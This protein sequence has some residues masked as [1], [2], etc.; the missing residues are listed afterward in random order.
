MQTIVF[1]VT[2]LIQLYIFVLLLRV[3]MQ[4]VRADFYNPFSQFV[5][6]AT[7]PIVGP[8]RRLIPSVGSID[9]ATLL[10]AFVLAIADIIF[11]MWA[12]NMLPAIGLT[13]LPMGLILLLTYIGKLIFW[14]ILIRAILSW[15]S[16]GRNPVDYL[17]FQL[18]EPLMAP[19]RRIIPAMGGLDFSA[20]I[21][22]FILIALNY[23][24]VD[25][26]LMIDPALTAMLFSVGIM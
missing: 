9:T 23:L 6:K 3:W 7:Q 1:V 26:S 20:M 22:M 25:V 24:R 16:Q 19:I 13:I 15:V 10:V 2:T 21:V 14:M 18:T 12:T 4:C 17:L 8:L 5:V 11:G